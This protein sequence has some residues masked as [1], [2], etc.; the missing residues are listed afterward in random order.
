MVHH[1][2]YRGTKKTLA[3]WRSKLLKRYR[4]HYSEEVRNSMSQSAV[5][6]LKKFDEFDVRALKALGK[7]ENDHGGASKVL[8]N[9][10]KKRRRV[11][12]RGGDEESESDDQDEQ[13]EDDSEDNDFY[14]LMS[15]AP[16]TFNCLNVKTEVEI[17]DPL[18]EEIQAP[19]INSHEEPME[20]TPQMSRR[21]RKNEFKIHEIESQE[22]QHAELDEHYE[23]NEQ[24]LSLTYEK[25]L[26][27]NTKAM[28]QHTAAI[29][30]LTDALNSLTSTIRSYMYNK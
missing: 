19:I 11:Y 7:W 9:R 4:Y 17:E 13:D 21:K 27:E 16:D 3:D 29:M 10:K 18:V 23:Q 26:L 30:G 8:N 22:H 12:R 14:S 1:K 20:P 5:K 6:N 24:N 15:P 28:K 2:V 25:V